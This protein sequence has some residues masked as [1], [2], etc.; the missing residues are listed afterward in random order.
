MLSNA[1]LIKKADATFAELQSGGGVLPAEKALSFWETTISGSALLKQIKTQPVD[2]P[3]YSQPKIGMDSWTFGP[4]GEFQKVS[5]EDRVKATYSS[6]T[7]TPKRIKFATKLSYEQLKLNIV[8][9]NLLQTIISLV[10]KAFSRDLAEWVLMA[11]TATVGSDMKSRSMR[12]TDGV[13]KRVTSNLLDASGVRLQK[14]V[15]DSMFRKMPKQFRA[16]EGLEAITSTIAAMDYVSSI[17]NRQTGAGDAALANISNATGGGM[18]GKIKCNG[19]EA[20]P[21]TLGSGDKTNVVLC[22]PKHIMLGMGQ[23]VM[24]E[25]AK[26]IEASC[27]NIVGSAWVDVTI[28]HNAAMVKATNVLATP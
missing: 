9:D 19:Y 15:L 23:E 11:D 28:L 26:D 1:E 24:I 5:E 17:S 18:Y 6:V 8:K 27:W 25:S 3:E 12:L 4:A 16:Q 10:G 13:L 22:N 2:G 7:L 21:E 14:S 20:M